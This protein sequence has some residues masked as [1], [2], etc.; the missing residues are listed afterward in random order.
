MSANPVDTLS[1]IGVNK[2]I[3]LALG[4]LG[5]GRRSQRTSGSLQEESRSRPQSARRLEVG[6]APLL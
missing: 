2:V 1:H 4:P 5:V 3:T 6:G